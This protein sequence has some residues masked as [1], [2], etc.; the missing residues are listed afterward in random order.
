MRSPRRPGSDDPDMSD[1]FQ[2]AAIEASGLARRYGA[3][4]VLRGVSLRVARGEVVGLLGTNGSGKSTLLRILATL[5]KPHAGSGSVWGHDIVR[6]AAAVRSQI[7][8]LAHSPG[9]YDDLTTR[10]NLTF[11][12]AMLGR[13]EGDIDRVLERVDLAHAAGTQVRALS[14]GM[15][16]RV[17]LARLM[18]VRPKV[19]FLDEPYSNLDSSGIALV[20]ALVGEWTAEGAAALVV[21]HELAP[22]APVLHRTVTLHEGRIASS[23]PNVAVMA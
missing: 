23:E 17:A 16:R 4:W 5:L 18:L 19:L 8:F 11:V 7:G 1:D 22:A 6:N 3:S 21:L 2:T 13:G 9:L 12:T 14:A 10:E 20:N 15:Q